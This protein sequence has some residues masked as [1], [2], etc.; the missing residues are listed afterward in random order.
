MTIADL[1]RIKM[2][3]EKNNILNKPS[4]Y[5][6]LEQI[7]N[8]TGDLLKRPSPEPGMT[9]KSALKKRLKIDE[10]AKMLELYITGQVSIGI[11]ASAFG[12]V[13]EG[14]LKEAEQLEHLFKK[15]MG[16]KLV[17]LTFDDA[18]LCHYQNVA[19]VLEKYGAKA[20]LCICEM[21]YGM[22]GDNSGFHDKSKFMTWRQIKE[23][24]VRGH[25]IVNHS[26][27]HERKFY[28]ESKE[29]KTEQI[30]RLE[31]RC[32]NNGIRK[33]IAFA[34]P[35]G[36][37]SIQDTMLIHELGYE[38][39]RGDLQEDA[40]HRSGSDYYEP[41]IDSPLAMPS[42]NNAPGFNREQLELLVEGITEDRV[43]VLVYHDVNEDSQ[44]YQSF[45][46]QIQTIYNS[47]GKCISF[48]ELSDYI[49]P[50]IAFKRHRLFE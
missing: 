2:N 38:W 1:L 37:A 22:M 18:R 20:N 27:H 5:I 9:M 50:L 11:I 42:F 4:R 7:R 44:L 24:Y 43:L 26:F 32:M 21:L 45:E 47:G 35:G 6:A 40:F 36:T 10:K 16:D 30:K 19:P 25:E 41:L 14:Q 49:D 39:A 3:Y 34:Y 33:P 17:I 15:K 23:L 46:E 12:I 31:N 48:R 13:E 29:Y 8:Q 28:T